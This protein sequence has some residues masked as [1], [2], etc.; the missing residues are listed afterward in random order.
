MIEGATVIKATDVGNG[1]TY[2]ATVVGTDPSADVAVI[3]LQG[4]S[5]LKTANLGDSATVAVGDAVVAIGNAGGAGGTPSAVTGTVQ[6]LDQ[7]I[8]ATDE[9]GGSPENL[10]GLIATDAPIQPGDS[11]GPLVDVHAKVIGIDTA[12]TAGFVF[13]Q[14]TTYGFAIP[15]DKAMSIVKQIEAGHPSSTVHLGAT[16]FLGV[17]VTDGAANGA[18]VV[19]VVNGSPAAKLGLQP[20]DVITSAGGQVVSSAESLTSVLQ[21]H[22]PGDRVDIVWTDNAGTQHHGTATLTTGPAA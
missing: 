21:Q 17:E 3:Q 22:H 2:T 19:G 8:R 20:G 13:N 7:S 18:L 15:I 10:T 11:G 12:A 4:A 5:G 16:G 9:F 1:R 6:A 14:G